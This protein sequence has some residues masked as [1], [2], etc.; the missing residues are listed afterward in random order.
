MSEPMRI[1]N[2]VDLS[3]LAKIVSENGESANEL[4]STLNN[5]ISVL[6]NK[7]S[8]VKINFDVAS[9]IDEIRAIP[10]RMPTQ[11]M[12]VPSINLN[13]ADLAAAFREREAND[14]I[15][16]EVDIKRGTNGKIVKM[17]FSPVR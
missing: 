13:T 11:E 4:I 8:D 15:S 16:Y 12:K 17:L 7:S 10:E 6:S 9:L 14:A 3:G 1:L 5:L 2:K